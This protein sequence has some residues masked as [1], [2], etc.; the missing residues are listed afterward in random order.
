MAPDPGHAIALFPE[1][2]FGPAAVRAVAPG[3]GPLAVDVE[4]LGETSARPGDGHGPS[5]AD[6]VAE[7]LRPVVAVGVGFEPAPSGTYLTTVREFDDGVEAGKR[8]K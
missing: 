8:R 7:R 1:P 2:V 4:R 5:P 3:R 6:F